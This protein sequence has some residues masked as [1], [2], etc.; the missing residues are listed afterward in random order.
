M[1][2]LGGVG[3]D[4]PAYNETK[5]DVWAS[6]DGKNWTLIKNNA[7]W[8]ARRGHTSVV[9]QDKIWIMGGATGE[10]IFLNDV[11]ASTNGIEWERIT[12]C[13]LY[14]SPSPRDA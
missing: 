8:R 2:V 11:W 13:L 7:P 1:W 3:G 14:T 6:D 10:E 5:N 12:S 9:F 4:Y